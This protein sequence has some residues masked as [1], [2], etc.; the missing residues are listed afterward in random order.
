VNILVEKRIPCPP[1]P[2][3]IICK[4]IY[5][6]SL[7]RGFNDEPLVTNINANAAIGADAPV[8]DHPSQAFVQH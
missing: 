2:D 6:S 5:A 7:K 8:N 4:F 3:R 1:T